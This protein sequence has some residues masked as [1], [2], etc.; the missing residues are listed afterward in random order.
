MNELYYTLLCNSIG[1][2]DLAT[3]K[4]TIFGEAQRGSLIVAGL[5]DNEL[6]SKAPP[7]DGHCLQL[8]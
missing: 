8:P 5:T 4:M 3:I 2:W 1:L 7:L 6:D